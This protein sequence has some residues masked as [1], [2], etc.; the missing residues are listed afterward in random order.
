LRCS[1]I[2]L[3]TDRPYYRAMPAHPTLFEDI[4]GVPHSV[5]EQWDNG[6]ATIVG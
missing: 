4:A 5:L 1:S 3:T 2:D 6:P